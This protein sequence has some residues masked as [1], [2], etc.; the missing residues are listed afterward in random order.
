MRPRGFGEA[1]RLLEEFAQALDIRA[2]EQAGE[3]TADQLG[4]GAAE[5]GLR[6]RRGA[7]DD[8]AAIGGDKT[9]AA[10]VGGQLDKGAHRQLVA[11]HPLRRPGLPHPR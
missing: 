1:R 6:R 3:G 5:G 9:F 10:R 2:G 8:A 11:A 4:F 7:G